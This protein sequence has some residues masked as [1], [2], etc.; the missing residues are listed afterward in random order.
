MQ[1]ELTYVLDNIDELIIKKA[2]RK[3]KFSS[4]L[5]DG[6]FPIMKKRN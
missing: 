5:W 3:S 6:F 4:D 1:K 2:N